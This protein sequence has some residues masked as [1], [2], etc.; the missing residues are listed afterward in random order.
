[1]IVVKGITSGGTLQHMATDREHAERIMAT[2]D[3]LTGKPIAWTTEHTDE[4]EIVA[5][6]FPE[7]RDTGKVDGVTDSTTGV[8]W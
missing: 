2:F 6:T 5:A 4:T 8:D 3:A 7:H 1:M